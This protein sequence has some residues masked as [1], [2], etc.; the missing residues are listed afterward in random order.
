MCARARARAPLPL[1][2]DRA[3]RSGRPQFNEWSQCVR[4]AAARGAIALLSGGT[5]VHDVATWTRVQF[6]MRDPS[7]SILYTGRWLGEHASSSFIDNHVANLVAPN[8]NASVFVC[9]DYDDL[10]CSAEGDM[11]F[12]RDARAAWKG[13]LS[14]AR[15][16]GG[17]L[18]TSWTEIV[19]VTTHAMLRAV[20][21]VPQ[22]QDEVNSFR[23]CQMAGFRLQ[24]AKVGMCELHRRGQP[25]P[26]GS[27]DTHRPA[28]AA[29]ATGRCA[30]QSWRPTIPTGTVDRRCG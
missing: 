24:F 23:V 8:G 18:G 3:G 25:L 6:L 27:R 5:I 30:R 19:N 13:H 4:V 9:A 2:P 20:S 12:L 26:A 7:V 1:L 22:A 10:E 16:L 28:R 14:G 21:D 11:A 15:W 17:G 29:W